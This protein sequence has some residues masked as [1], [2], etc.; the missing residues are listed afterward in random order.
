[1]QK[2]N[3][4]I[5]GDS[6]TGVIGAA[7]N[8][9]GARTAL[10]RT[11]NVR[12]A[13][14]GDIVQSF[15]LDLADGRSII[16]PAVSVHFSPTMQLAKTF[17]TDNHV[18]LLFGGLEHNRFALRVAG[19]EFDF[20]AADGLTPPLTPGRRFVSRGLA[21]AALGQTFAELDRGLGLVAKLSG[22]GFY[23]LQGPPPA[24]DNAA[25]E[26]FFRERK[27]VAEGKDVQVSDP[28]FRARI[29]ALAGEVLAAMVASHGGVF[30]PA[31]AAA[32]QDGLL[33]AD[34][35]GDPY[36]ANAAY[37]GLALEALE[38]AFARAEQAEAA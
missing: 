27:L 38:A 17:W 21:E 35:V 36:H 11:Y 31:P 30:I 5:I 9:A 1:M 6:H 23:V 2:K 33:R 32:F 29:Y 12:A 25:I 24:P 20:P 13:S 10:P 18:V 14:N 26:R 22:R 4:Y 16:N 37:G 8:A 28:Q 19:R 3:V 7:L 34:L 15:V